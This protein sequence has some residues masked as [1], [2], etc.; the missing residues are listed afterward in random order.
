MALALGYFVVIYRMF[1]GQIAAEYIVFSTIL[2]KSK[3]VNLPY[4]GAK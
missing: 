2:H 3:L 4:P 1:R